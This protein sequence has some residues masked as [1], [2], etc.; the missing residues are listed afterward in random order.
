MLMITSYNCTR[1]W[2][3]LGYA[4][5]LPY[6][7]TLPAARAAYPHHERMRQ[8]N[9]PNP[10]RDFHLQLRTHPLPAYSI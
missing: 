10:N 7:G 1:T 6:Q 3:L 9:G 5:G 4:L 8:T 2:P